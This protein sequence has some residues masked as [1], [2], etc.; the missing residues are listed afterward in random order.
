MDGAFGLWV[1]ATEQY[2]HLGAGIELADSW[3]AD[4][5][6]WLNVSYD[7]GIVLCKHPEALK[8]AMT[9]HAPYFVTGSQREPNHFSPEQS[10][11]ARGIEIWAALK[12]LGKQGLCQLIER[13]CQ[14]ATQFAR[15]LREAGFG[16]LNEVAINQV[17]V[18][19][20]ENEGSE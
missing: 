17:L 15:G 4:A 14:L 2:K 7:N 3:A 13:D 6:K 11:R 12:S 8:N 1:R 5:H 18:A 20:D 10:R 16:V 19:F 9:V